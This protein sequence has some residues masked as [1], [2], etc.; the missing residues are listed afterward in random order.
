MLPQ[1][2]HP[3]AE[4]GAGRA[5]AAGGLPLPGR[6]H[7]PPQHRRHGRRGRAA[8]GN[9]GFE[10][11]LTHLIRIKSYFQVPPRQQTKNRELKERAAAADPKVNNGAASPQPPP[12]SKPASPP[13]VERGRT[14]E[15][16]SPDLKL[17]HN[18]LLDSFHTQVVDGRIESGLFIYDLSHMNLP[19]LRWRPWPRP[20]TRTWS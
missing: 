7:R 8:A 14:L 6:R 10:S 1:E 15:V 20:P 16:S 3:D 9:V 18:R 4:Q 5:A 19:P 13:P 11:H 2:L 12:E 17:H